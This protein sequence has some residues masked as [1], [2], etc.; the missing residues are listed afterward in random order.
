MPWPL[1]R[2]AR[3]FRSGVQKTS[4]WI[5]RNPGVEDNHVTYEA[6]KLTLEFKCQSPQEGCQPI[7]HVVLVNGSR[8]PPT[9]PTGPMCEIPRRRRRTGVCAPICRPGIRNGPSQRTALLD[10]EPQYE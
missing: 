7:L 4:G 2:L 5:M 1:P 9:T 3:G 6:R 8:V 10:F